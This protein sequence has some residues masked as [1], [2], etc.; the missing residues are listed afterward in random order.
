MSVLFAIAMLLLMQVLGEAIA[1]LTGVPLPGSLIGMLLMLIALIA[2]GK[3]PS[4]LRDTSQHMLKHLMLLFIPAVAGVMQYFGPLREEW[5]PF[6][7]SCV[8]GVALTIAV[9]AIV[10]SWMLKRTQAGK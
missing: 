2:Y 7:L 5:I 8:L 9:T 10:F 4:G 1:R 3:V 6:L